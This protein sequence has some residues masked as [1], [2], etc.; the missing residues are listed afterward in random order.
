M[1]QELKGT[2]TLLGNSGGVAHRHV[3]DIEGVRVPP[4]ADKIGAYIGEQ[5]QKVLVALETPSNQHY[6][7]RIAELEAKL[8]VG[9]DKPAKEPA[10]KPAPKK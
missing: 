7:E 5:V 9:L 1:Y 6:I 8:G 3:F 4:S 10:D 2:I